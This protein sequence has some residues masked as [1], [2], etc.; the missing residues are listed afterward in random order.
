MPTEDFRKSFVDGAIEWSFPVEEFDWSRRKATR[1][2][3]FAHGGSG[4]WWVVMEYGG[5]AP[6]CG[7][8]ERGKREEGRKRRRWF[9][10]NG[11]FISGR[12]SEWKKKEEKER[13]PAARRRE[14]KE[15]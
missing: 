3:R 4:R 9:S 7:R 5:A 11:D 1:E 13:G 10:G 8:P 15:K 2:G 6:W 14:K 12:W